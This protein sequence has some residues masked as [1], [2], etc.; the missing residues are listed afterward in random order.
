MTPE[1]LALGDAVRGVID[2]HGADAWPHL[3]RDIGVAG[4]LIPERFGGL[5]ASVADAAA[6]LEALGRDLTAA[7]MLG[8]AVLA[9][10]A[11]LAAGDTAACERLLPGVAAGDRTLAVAWA[12]RDGRWAF[13]AVQARPALTGAAHYVLDGCT[14][15]TLLVAA[16][17]A[18]GDALYEVS[19]EAPG[20]RR[21]LVTTLDATRRL[22][23]VSF[24][25]ATGA[26]L[27]T[28]PGFLARVRDV[29]CAAL[30]AE[31]VGAAARAL[32]RTVA[33]SLQRVQF[34]RPIGAFQALAHRMA[35]LHVLVESARSASWAAVRADPQELTLLAAVAKVHCSEALMQVA[36]EMIQLHGG[37]AITWEHDAHRYLRRAYGDAQLFGSPADHIA[38][39]WA[40]IA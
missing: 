5:G 19:P 24:D 16:S 32:E 33:Y 39:V 21:E 37:I 14:A 18:D 38:R 36:G 10:Q 11:L 30:S 34:G 27:D 3:C 17:T 31:Q 20:V 35:D 9:V 7:P 2:R 6:V 1:Q 12:G 29:A 8:S 26:R 13:P 40:S 25:G 22:A 15:D 4:L 23:V 28:A